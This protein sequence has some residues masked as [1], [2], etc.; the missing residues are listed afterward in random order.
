[1]NFKDPLVGSPTASFA[2]NMGMVL[3]LD[4]THTLHGQ[5]ARIHVPQY[6]TS[7]LTEMLHQQLDD[8]N[9]DIEQVFQWSSTGSTIPGTESWEHLTIFILCIP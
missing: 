4:G 1:M 3:S 5:H 7:C 6:Y 2:T 9:Q 8:I